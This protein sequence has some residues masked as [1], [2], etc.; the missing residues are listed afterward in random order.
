MSNWF[1]TK[2]LSPYVLDI[3]VFALNLHVSLFPAS[4]WCRFYVVNWYMLMFGGD[5]KPLY[6]QRRYK[7]M[8]LKVHISTFWIDIERRKKKLQT[9]LQYLNNDHYVQIQWLIPHTCCGIWLCWSH[10]QK[11]LNCLTKILMNKTWT[12]WSILIKDFLSTEFVVYISYHVTSYIKYYP[13]VF[14]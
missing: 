3:D 14:H 10:R 2:I 7:V 5:N 11:F 8:K 9:F 13:I 1:S 6:F 12:K 4:I